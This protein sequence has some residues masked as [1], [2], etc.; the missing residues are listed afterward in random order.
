MLLLC[1]KVYVM[2]ASCRQIYPYFP[3]SVLK[4]HQWIIH[5]GK[6]AHSRIPVNG[7]LRTT[8]F[9]FLKC[10]IIYLFYYSFLFVW[11]VGWMLAGWLSLLLVASQKKELFLQRLQENV[12]CAFLNNLKHIEKFHNVFKNLLF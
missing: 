5:L 1:V 11:L 6:I 4:V 9:L 10:F 3:K 8:K 12:L 7:N 2:S